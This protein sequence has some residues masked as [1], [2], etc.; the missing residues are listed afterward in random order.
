MELQRIAREEMEM[1]KVF[2]VE[3]GEKTRLELARVCKCAQGG[4]TQAEFSA[5]GGREEEAEGRAERKAPSRSVHSSPVH[6]PLTIGRSPSFGPISRRSQW[7][8]RSTP[9]GSSPSLCH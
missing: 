4:K 8:A 2:V 1:A 5:V 3:L 6:A 9:Q 7:P